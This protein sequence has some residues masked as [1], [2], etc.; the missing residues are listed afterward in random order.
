MLR[1]YWTTD[2][3]VRALKGKCTTGKERRITKSR[4]HPDDRM[5]SSVSGHLI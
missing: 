4:L 3:L 5:I 2:C 1:R